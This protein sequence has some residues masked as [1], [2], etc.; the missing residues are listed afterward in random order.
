MAQYKIQ[1]GDTL[2]AL[3]R[4]YGTTV[5]ALMDANKQIKDKD[6]IYYDRMMNVPG[7]GTVAGTPPTFAGGPSV[8][9]VDDI[10]KA[11]NQYGSVAP[12]PPSAVDYAQSVTPNQADIDKV[13]ASSGSFADA[14][15]SVKDYINASRQ[16]QIAKEQETGTATGMPAFKA[17]EM[18]ARSQE[19]QPT[20]S[21]I[22]QYF[23]NVNPEQIA[24]ATT[25]GFDP[26][27][28]AGQPTIKDML[29]STPPPA[30]NPYQIMEGGSPMDALSPIK[31]SV[32]KSANKAGTAVKEVI[33]SAPDAIKGAL[34]NFANNEIAPILAGLNR[35]DRSIKDG[36]LTNLM[37]KY[38]DSVSKYAEQGAESFAKNIGII[39]KDFIENLSD[40]AQNNNLDMTSIVE[41]IDVDALYD[42]TGVRN[43]K[44]DR[45]E[46]VMK[47][48]LEAERNARMANLQNQNASQINTMMQPTSAYA[49]GGLAQQAA[50][51][52]SKGRYGDT[53]LM[54]VNP[55]EVAGLSQVMPLTVNPDT[56]QPEAFLPFLLPLLGSI[57]GSAL[58]TAV[59]ALAGKGLLL[60]AIGSGLGTYAATGDAKKGLLSAALGFGVGK[61][62]GA[63]ATAAKG[64]TDVAT[65][66]PAM[67]QIGTSTVNPITS[68]LVPN[69]GTTAVNA[70]SSALT[71]ATQAANPT[72]LS[73]VKD[74][75]SAPKEGLGGFFNQM[76]KPSSYLPTYVGAAGYGMMNSQE[77]FNN[78]MANLKANDTEEYNRI[79]AE[80]PEYVPMLQQNQMFARGGQAKKEFKPVAA[81]Q[82]R[83]IDPN[84]MAGFQGERGY[85]KNVNPSSGQ[86]IS[87]KTGYDFGTEM[88][89][90]PMSAPFD[91]T[92]TAGYKAFYNAPREPYVLDPYAKQT[93]TQPEA[94]IIQPI[95]A[96]PQTTEPEPVATLPVPPPEESR[97]APFN[98]ASYIN[99]ESLNEIASMFSPG[100]SREAKEERDTGVPMNGMMDVIAPPPREAPTP[101]PRQAPPPMYMADT[102]GLSRE[103]IESGAF[104]PSMMASLAPMP[105]SSFDYMAPP[106][107]TT[108]VPRG[109]D[110]AQRRGGRNRKAE[111]GPTDLPNEGLEALNKVAPDAVDAMG[112]QEGGLTEQA[113]T[114]PLT[115]EVVQYI[116]GQS[117]NDE[118]IAQFVNKYGNEAFMQLREMALQ[119][120]SPPQAQTEGLVAGANM[121]GMTDDVPMT[122]S[123]QPAAVSQGEFI[124]PSDVVSMLG[125]G[126]TESG[127]NSLYGMMDR[128]RKTKTGTTD[129]APPF[130]NLAEMMPA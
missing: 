72:V 77:D 38:S 62:L 10:N 119:Q 58:A 14:F 46:K 51:V 115:Q 111:G 101:A 55:A 66:A 118:A 18:Q 110:R 63:G 127:A 109:Q 87:G 89:D 91:P 12:A 33:T 52:A 96:P 54:H 35:V 94:P 126:D 83:D 107:L 49:G 99:P 47:A 21:D 103:E 43:K 9:S 2:T 104:D 130:N 75:A 84:F 116:T 93:F 7:A 100:M 125:D 90:A 85:L 13:V 95:V 41:A 40:F 114:D 15:G 113:M 121:G 76:T 19:G 124:V 31:D 6:L 61:A 8:A 53:M 20:L 1:Q 71:G 56:G 4:K 81:I 73:T 102:S 5:D 22:G 11:V 112:Y 120:V 30:T 16:E 50:N 37:K 48:K 82:A 57:G 97:V 108:V 122:I 17:P 32:I 79:L 45:E 36:D 106:P 117:G 42:A 105:T 25:G 129:Q 68:A 69:A 44:K 70:S 65:T 23:T 74:I 80:H 34:S 86:I 3:A 26:S 92:Q 123:G 64:A 128:V 39:R 60:G 24:G 28:L 59:P 67:S 88:A 27:V 98:P 78:A 29:S